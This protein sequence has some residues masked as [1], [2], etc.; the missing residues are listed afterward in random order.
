[1]SNLARL[2]LIIACL[3]LAGCLFLDAACIAMMKANP[4]TGRARGCYTTVE[5]FFGAKSPTEWV[6]P[7]QFVASAILCFYGIALIVAWPKDK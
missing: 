4:A 1:M 5:L 2:I 3:L 6:R 7:A